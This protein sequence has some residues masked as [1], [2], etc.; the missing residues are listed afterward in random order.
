MGFDRLANTLEWC[1]DM[2]VNEVTVYAFSIENFK[3]T[4]H[5][6]D[7]LMDLAKRK[8]RELLDDKATVA[9]HGVRFRFF[10]DISRLP[11]DL[12]QLL[13][14]ISLFTRDFDKA[15]INVCLAYTAQDEMARAVKAVTLGVEKGLIEAE[16]INES[17]ISKCLDTR[18]S[19]D[20]DLL[21]RTSGEARMSDF[22][23]W[24]SSTCC[25]HFENVLWPDFSFYHLCM[26]VLHYQRNFTAIQDIRKQ[27]RQATDEETGDPTRIAQFLDW[28]EQSKLAELQRLAA[29]STVN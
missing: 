27:I 20:P 25:L 1:R 10:G 28:F 11:A 19:P 3:R 22:M 9:K 8:F 18:S 17:L 6:V 15:F 29:G 24:Q 4:E 21:V 2:G 26:A 14:E 23:L 5:E 16:D 12:Q 13:A 7:G